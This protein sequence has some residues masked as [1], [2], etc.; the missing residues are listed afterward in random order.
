M[1]ENKVKYIVASCLLAGVFGM[2]VSASPILATEDGLNTVYS[3]WTLAGAGLGGSPA[4][5]ALAGDN[6]AGTTVGGQPNNMQI[7]ASTGGDAQPRTEI[8]YT[9]DGAMTG[10]YNLFGPDS[11]QVVGTISFDFYAGADDGGNAEG[12]NAPLEL[13]AYFQ[14]MDGTVWLYAFDPTGISGWDTYTAT[15]GSGSGWV[16]WGD[17]TFSTAATTT[18]TDAFADVTRIGIYVT[19]QAD[20]D[21]QVFGLGDVNLSV[22]VSVVVPEPETYMILGMAL[23][24]VGVVFRR[25]ITDS[26]A[27]VR[28]M[29]QA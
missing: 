21:D 29:L 14:T 18:F 23:L 28:A 9:A 22:S 15:F 24:S 6:G 11:D 12:I 5:S 10:N 25:R 3:D 13:G 2:N 19:Y 4:T 1:Q 7:T 26:L 20:A 17:D 16:G 8:L 27:E